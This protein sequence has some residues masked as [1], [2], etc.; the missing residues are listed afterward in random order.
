MLTQMAEPIVFPDTLSQDCCDLIS[1]MLDPEPE[2][3][4]PVDKIAKV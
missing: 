4:I 3:R 2:K 1:R